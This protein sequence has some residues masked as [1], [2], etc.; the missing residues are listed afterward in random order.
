LNNFSEA[1]DALEASL[2]IAPAQLPARILLGKAYLELKNPAA[3]AD[4]FEAVLLLDPKNADAMS[5]LAQ[6]QSAEKSN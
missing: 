4:Q 5:G 1:R 2:K 6:A 3:A